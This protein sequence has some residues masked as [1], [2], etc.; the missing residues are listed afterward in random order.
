MLRLN[1]NAKIGYFVCAVAIVTI[2]APGAFALITG[3]EGNEP[4]RDPGWPAGVAAIFN[5]EARIAWWEG[6]PFGGGQWHAE[7]CGSS[8][9]LNSLLADFAK[10]DV[11]TKRI[12]VHDGVGRSFW[13]NPNREREKD[14]AA[15]VDWVF[16]V[17]QP[18]RWE[19][20]RKMPAH[21]HRIAPSEGELGPPAQIDIYTGGAI[22]WN[23]ITIP[24]GLEVIDER[25]EAH[26]FSLAD[27]TVLEGNVIDL[28]TNAP[29]AARVELQLIEPQSIG[30]YR[31]T[32]V[33]ETAADAKGHWVLKKAPPGWHR[34]V[35]DAS[36]YVPRIVGHER[37]DD[38]PGW[39]SYESGL[40]RLA[41]VSGRISDE[42]GQPLA[43]VE[44]RLDDIASQDGRYESPHEYK[45]KSDAEGR[46]RIEQV[47]LGTTRIWLRKPG[48][49]RP[50]L[51]LEIKSPIDDVA[52]NMVRSAELRIAVDFSKTT[53]PE[54]YLVEVEP[55]G[56]SVV[57]SWGGSANIDATNQYAF[58]NVPPGRY[59]VNGR[60]NPGSE[61][62]QAGPMTVELKGGQAVDVTLTAK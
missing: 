15:Q 60:P 11:K 40:S 55:E 34:I 43:D 21:L 26:G 20:L 8:N 24:A 12:V 57:G 2:S 9:V 62:Q 41:S 1:V 30:G 56:G 35:I 23:E 22:R 37:F 46:F 42:G 36:G 5:H 33:T 61:S 47:P 44:V 14:K 58:S 13:L 29:I 54:A 38:Q 59:V 3:G 52:L 6:P 48:Y 39:H 18:A 32:R 17:W 49:C 53:R 45:A 51:G 27:G 28:D 25:L 16:T 7:F 31:Y 10:L 50:G 4:I 19:Q